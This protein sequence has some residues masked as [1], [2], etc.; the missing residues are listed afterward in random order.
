MKNA[1]NSHSKVPEITVAFWAIKIAATTLG[2]TAGDAVSMTL[3]LGYAAS[4]IIFAAFFIATLAAQITA[5][6]FHS[7][8]YWT[9][10]VATTTVGTTMADFAD[11]SLG[12]GYEGGVIILSSLLFLTLAAWRLTQKKIT[13]KNIRATKVEIF[14][15]LTILFSNTLGTALGDY[16]ADDS[17]YGYEGSALI[18][19]GILALI[20]GAFYATKI[21]R[22]LLFWFGFI[23]T[24]PLGATLG[25]LLTKSHEKGGLNLSRISSSAVIAVFMIA[26]IWLSG[27]PSL[28]KRA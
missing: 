8:I 23:F 5:K 2:E 25:D 4:T 26:L 7:Y 10:I 21:S 20:A 15:W 1:Q 16:F 22:S 6:T 18:F 3:Q 13:F 19:G 28:K 24:R 12:L 14:Y 11:R 27:L 9:V 17:G